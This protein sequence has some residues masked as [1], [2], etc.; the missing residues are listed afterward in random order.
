M[1]DGRT[2]RIDR[3]ALKPP[4]RRA[5]GSVRYDAALTRAGVFTYMNPDGSTRKEYRSVAEVGNAESLAS[6]ELVHVTDNH[7]AN[8]TDAKAVAVGAVGTNVAFDGRLV[9]ASL[10][11]REDAVNAKIASGKVETS[12][13]YDCV[14]V[15]EP[16]VSPEGERYD[17][18]QTC[19]RYDHVA[20]VDRGRAG[21]EV[22]I[23]MDAA[24]M[25]TEDLHTMSITNASPDLVKTLADLA[26]ANTAL[27]AA[28]TRA[29]AA[30]RQLA[31]MTAERDSQ[32]A[33]ADSAERASASRIDAADV[34]QRVK[35]RVALES[36]ALLILGA[37]K[38]SKRADMSDRD[39]MVSIV[40]HVDGDDIAGTESDAYVSG[41]FAG[42]LKHAKRADTAA[43][44]VREAIGAA[45]DNTRT[46]AGTMNSDHE[47]RLK[48]EERRNERWRSDT[49]DKSAT[50]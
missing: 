12:C 42:A 23:R 11:V 20:I 15:L 22:R 47:A 31:A 32:R 17:V 43:G 29:D 19:I 3:G 6:L 40:K 44:G 45:G 34:R 26:A 18:V 7:P 24:E 37:D 36:H 46:D 4:V 41:R 50:K 14:L 30:E 49:A 25:Q 38:D 35:D 2:Y 10:M 48:S 33:R 1:A 39:L 13:G 28:N 27:V 21:P 16:G 5:D 8:R 9:T